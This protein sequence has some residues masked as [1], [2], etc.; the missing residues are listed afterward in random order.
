MKI[1]EITVVPVLEGYAGFSGIGK[2]YG[3]V[4]QGVSKSLPNPMIEPELRNT[5]AYMQYRYSIALAAAAA[6]QDEEFSQETAWAE[7]IGLVGYVAQDLEQIKAADKLMGVKSLKLSDGKSSEEDDV[8]NISP[9]ADNSWR[10][11]SQ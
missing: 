8:G 9:V 11:A 1:T 2:S 10:K 6:H 3:K 5:D 7:N 4:K